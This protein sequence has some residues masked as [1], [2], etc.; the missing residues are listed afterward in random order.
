MDSSF[1]P[2]TW[3]SK[4]VKVSEEEQNIPLGQYN[5]VRVEKK[6]IE[7]IT[8]FVQSIFNYEQIKVTLNKKEN[9]NTAS[10]GYSSGNLVPES[11]HTKFHFAAK[12]FNDQL[13]EFSV[14]NIPATPESSHIKIFFT[15]LMEYL[16]HFNDIITKTLPVQDGRLFASSD[17]ITKS[18]IWLYNI[19]RT[20]I[21]EYIYNLFNTFDKD[22]NSEPKL[23]PNQIRYNIDL[24]NLIFDFGI[25]LSTKKVENKEIY[26]GFIFHDD[27]DEVKFNSVKSFK[28]E[29]QFDFGNFGQLKS[30]LEISNGQNIFFNVTNEKITH[31]F[32]TKDKLNEIY[33]SPMGNGKTFQSR[34]LILS[35]Q[36]NGNI[37]FLE[38]RSDQNKI[39]LQIVNSQPLIRDNDFIKKFIYNSLEEFTTVDDIKLEVF[40]KWIMSLSQRKHGTSLLFNNI[41]NETQS[42]LVKSIQITFDSGSFLEKRTL[43]Y[44]LSLLDSITNPDGAVIFNKNLTPT[45]I[46]T[47]LP[48]GQNATGESGGA[49]HNSI[50]NFTN[51]FSCLGIVISEDGPI[52]IFKN[53]KKLIKF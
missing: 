38:G 5:L 26:C 49:R 39:L 45:H 47:I 24:I 13:Y 6:F 37:Y 27:G 29:K 23:F 4:E 41:T 42:K 19:K 3:R 28:F 14:S 35:V 2:K 34:P 46:S 48:I 16:F 44:D 1:F 18:D 11:G 51:E 32:I 43:P 53:G 12:L 40:S 8:S 25:E 9:Y 36:G 52:T 15:V 10:K 20:I 22:Y 21:I 33:L 17:F 30:Y 31:L 50:A 7:V